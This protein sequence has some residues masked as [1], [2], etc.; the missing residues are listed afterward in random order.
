MNRQNQ[1][2]KDQDHKLLSDALGSSYLV[3]WPFSFLQCSVSTA[4]WSE[5][6]GCL[7]KDLSHL[8]IN[9][10]GFHVG[11]YE[12]LSYDKFFE[13]FFI[14]AFTQTKFVLILK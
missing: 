9:K 13:R 2:Q 5:V 14:Q 3:R 7:L 8:M 1:G 11:E 6:Y 4:F 12:V 10:L